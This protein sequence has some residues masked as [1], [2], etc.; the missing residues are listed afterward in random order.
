MEQKHWP[1]RHFPECCIL[2]AHRPAREGAG[3]V[4]WAAA[5]L[6]RDGFGSISHFPYDAGHL[7]V[8]TYRSSE[9]DAKRNPATRML[10]F[11]QTVPEYPPPPRKAMPNQTLP[12]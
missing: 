9:S 3:L 1:S 11:M 7:G 10:M 6:G 2:I 5:R 8:V 4:A 12:L